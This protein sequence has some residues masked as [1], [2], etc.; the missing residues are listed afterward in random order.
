MAGYDDTRAKIINTLMG[1]PNGTE[2]QPE[3]HQDYALNM[4]DYIRS[5]ELDANSTLIGIADED[6][7]PIQP[8]A[9]NVCYLAG[10]AQDRTVTFQNFRDYQGEPLSITTGEMQSYFVIL[11]WN[12]K[13][14]SMQAL[15]T[16]IVSQA[17]TAYF[18]YSY[19]IRQTYPSFEAMEADK[20]NPI[21]IDGKYIKQGEIVSVVNDSDKSKNGFYSYTGSG[22]QFQSAFS[23]QIENSF[24]INND[25]ELNTLLDELHGKVE[26]GKAKAGYFRGDYEGSPFMVESI[27]I[28]Y[29]EDTW[30]QS[31]RGRFVPVY[32]GTV[33][34][35]KTLARSNTEYNILWRICD[36]GTWSTWNSMTDAP[37]IPDT[38][39]SM[40][41]KDG[42][43]SSAYIQMFTRKGGCYSVTGSRTG[44][45]TGTMM[46]FCDSWGEH[47][48]EQVLFT[49]AS[50]IEG[51]IVHDISSSGHVD[52]EP[53]IYHR[54]YDIR[55][56]GGKWGAW[57]SFTTGGGT[58]VPLYVA[59]DFG[60]LQEKI[61]SGRT[62]PDLDAF[63]LTED[64]WAKIRGAEI[65]VVR[66][67]A[68]ERTYIVTGSSDYYISFAYGMS[69]TYEGWEI[70]QSGNNYIISRHQTQSNTVAMTQEEYD[71]LEEKDDGTFYFIYED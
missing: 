37:A 36:K 51:K 33:D 38:D 68:N 47:G 9:S 11:L 43:V 26:D 60:V 44:V 24:D 54:Y 13:Y 4:L 39:L 16:A 35:I 70:K 1:R 42:D 71:A 61:G 62:Q 20:S 14:W 65:M 59:F 5:L 3:N 2:I 8:N 56:S 41:L 57:K 31:V 28:N 67:D 66:D 69:E 12:K 58:T 22:W 40:G 10:V 23:F 63:G 52:G 25:S 45:V 21:G 7:V 55:Q 18:Y 50:D 6:T 15:P 48:I 53:R 46:V 64:V 49:D 30:V 17:E 27:P 19:T 29:T 32:Q 34:K